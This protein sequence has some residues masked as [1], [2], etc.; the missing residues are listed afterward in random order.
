MDG[1]HPLPLLDGQTTPQRRAQTVTLEFGRFPP[2]PYR[3]RLVLGDDRL[4]VALPRTAQLGKSSLRRPEITLLSFNLAVIA[5]VHI[6]RRANL[7]SK[8]LFIN[9]ILTHFVKSIAYDGFPV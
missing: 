4:S 2:H 1:N 8:S 9:A 6:D 7:G 3:H 5:A